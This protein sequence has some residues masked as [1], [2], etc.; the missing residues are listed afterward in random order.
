M[1]FVKVVY[2]PVIR[3]VQVRLELRMTPAEREKIRQNISQL[4]MRKALDPDFG[5]HKRKN[6]KKKGKKKV[7][8]DG[9]TK[10]ERKV[11]MAEFRAEMKGRKSKS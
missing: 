4:K 5:K 9:L 1:M 3:R 8:D 10:E 7:N 6:P 2:V 11:L